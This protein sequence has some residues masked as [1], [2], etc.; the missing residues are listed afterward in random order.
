MG[1]LVF[2]AGVVTGLLL[3]AGVSL[4]GDV[5]YSRKIRRHRLPPA[6]V[7]QIRR[8]ARANRAEL[9]RF[10]GRGRWISPA[11]GTFD[12]GDTAA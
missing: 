11:S 9:V 12:D 1:L 2:L 3:A 4:V 8:A 10:P 5:L 6:T 7:R